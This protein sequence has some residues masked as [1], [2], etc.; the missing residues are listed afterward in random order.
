MASPT[1]QQPSVRSGSLGCEKLIVFSV[2]EAAFQEKMD[3]AYE[4]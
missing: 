2:Q 1:K 3:S 4:K